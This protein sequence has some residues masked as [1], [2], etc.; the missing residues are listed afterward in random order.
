MN[1]KNPQLFKRF[2]VWLRTPDP[3]LRT[4]DLL[5]EI[6]ENDKIRTANAEADGG[7]VLPGSTDDKIQ[8]TTTVELKLLCSMFM[9]DDHG[10]DSVLSKR[11][12]PSEDDIIG[13]WLDSQANSHGYYSWVEAY[14]EID[15]ENNMITSASSDALKDADKKLVLASTILLE[16]KHAYEVAGGDYDNACR[17]LATLKNSSQ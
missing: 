16:T 1:V 3:L 4:S 14:L 8:A 17:E 5:V 11:G 6:W 2:L 13:Y 9:S 7:Q 10:D 15:N 12:N